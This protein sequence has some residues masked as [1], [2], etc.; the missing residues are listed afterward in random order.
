MSLR[1]LTLNVWGLPWP[2]GSSVPERI[3]AIGAALPALA[4]DVAAFQEAWTPDTRDALARA[5]DRA[6]LPHAFP[7]PSGPGRGGL[8]VLSRH[9]LRDASFTR[10]RL[11]GLPERIDQADYWGGKGFV[12][13]ELATPSGAIGFVTTH[14]HA[15]YAP[16]RLDAYVGHRTAQVVQLAA[17]LREIARPVIAAGDFNFEERFEEYAVLRGLAGVRDV[18]AVLDRRRDTVRWPGSH[19]RLPGLGGARIDYVFCRGGRDGSW[20]PLAIERVLDGTTAIGRRRANYS[21]HA[22]LVADLELVPGG[23]PLPAADPEAV[24]VARDLLERGRRQAAGR[25]SALRWSGAGGLAAAAVAARPALRAR[26]TRRRFLG[27]G[28]AALAG[29]AGAGSLF[30]AEEVRPEEI[31][32]FDATL[33]QL[34]A[35]AAA[36]ARGVQRGARSG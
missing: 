22:G 36:P 4:P 28:V 34:D 15:R 14:L 3:D 25:R 30:L 26:L 1:V 7:D 27:A 2:F 31:R 17:A 35:L 24:D 32:A 12:A 18:A 10:F 5:G 16:R 29:L 19:R 20:R 11:N 6:G 33:R 23:A 21:D 13:C 9:P 8:L